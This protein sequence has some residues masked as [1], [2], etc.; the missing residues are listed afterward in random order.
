MKAKSL[1]KREWYQRSG[2]LRMKTRMKNTTAF[3][4]T[5]RRK[6]SRSCHEGEKQTSTSNSV[7][8]GRELIHI[9]VLSFSMIM[10]SR[11][12]KRVL[13]APPNNNTATPLEFLLRES[14]ENQKVKEN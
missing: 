2:S 14:K 8:R 6:H 7:E 1:K 3:F 11:K 5:E 9:F 13:P 10:V 12:G 4:I